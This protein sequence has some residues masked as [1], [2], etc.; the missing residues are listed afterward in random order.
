MISLDPRDVCL[1]LCVFCVVFCA[2]QVA[3]MVREIKEQAN[4]ITDYSIRR[5]ESDVY[6]QICKRLNQQQQEEE[7]ER[8]L[9]ADGEDQ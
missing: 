1:Y 8:S 6:R 9:T 7:L 3:G 4:K 2:F 5:A